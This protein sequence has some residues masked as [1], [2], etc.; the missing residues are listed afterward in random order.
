MKSK[1]SVFLVLVLSMQMLGASGASGAPD[2]DCDDPKWQDHPAC[3]TT[4]ST[5]T[6]TTPEPPVVE[7]C[8]AIPPI[9]VAKGGFVGIECD[10]IPTVQEAGTTGK[11]TVKVDGE[12]SWLVVVVRDSNPGDICV[13]R[14]WDRPS[15][16]EFEAS[17]PLV[18]NGETYWES[19]DNWCTWLVSGFR[20][21]LNGD[22]LN[23][24]VNLRG[25]KGTTAEVSLTP[26]QAP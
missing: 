10:W 22:A 20:D 14:E 5:T 19:P 24:V 11:V 26:A 17:F 18:A 13:L 23:V 7:S 3:Q 1:L 25:R 4:S 21:D 12:I 8:G 16:A 15:A 9:E 6:T 2:R